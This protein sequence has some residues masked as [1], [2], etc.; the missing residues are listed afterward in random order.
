MINTFKKKS[1]NRI[2]QEIYAKKQIASGFVVEFGAESG[3]TKNFT[4]FIQFKD[5]LKTTY[6][7][8]FPKHNETKEEDLEEKLTL[9]DNSQDNIIIF[10]VLEHVF[11]TKN[12]FLEINRCLKS[13]TGT[14]IGSTPF[15][16]R[17]HGAPYDYSR[18]TKQYLEKILEKSNFKNIKVENLGFG[19]FTSAYVIIFDYLKL[20]PSLNNIILTFCLILDKSI[21]LIVKTETKNI[22]PITVCFTAE[23]K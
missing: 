23:K 22:Y 21:S 13:N 6:C 12:A 14:I 4:N 10:N 16:H 19:A 9:L 15:M 7:D 20:I 1:L 2:L 8:K 18:Y 3:S 11:D 5:V 17:V